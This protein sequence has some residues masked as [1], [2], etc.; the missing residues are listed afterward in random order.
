[1]TQITDH[2]PQFL[3]VWHACIP[4]KSLSY[5]QHDFSNLN[6]GKVLNDFASLNLSFL[7]DSALDVNAKFNRLLSSL[8][9]LV[10]THAPLKKL[11]KSDIKFRNKPWIN[12]KIQKMM[13]IRDNL[14]KKIKK[15]KDQSLID[16]YKQFRNRVT[17]T[18][19][20]S[21]TS[22]FYNY[23][24]KN[25]NNMKQ[26]WSGIKS[27]ISIRKS[28]NVN[29]ISELKDSNGNFTSGPAVIANIFNKFFVNVS[30]DI[31]KNIPPSNKSPLS[32][33]G[34]RVGNSFSMSPSVPSEISDVISVLKSGKSL[35][36]NSIPMKILKLLS[37]LIS[38][39]LSLIINESFQSGVF[40][41][42]MKLAKVIPL[43]KK[44]C[45]L[46]SSNYRPI[47]LLS[48]FSKIVEKVM[49]E[50]LYKFLEKHE[51]LHTLQFGF[52]ASHS[53]NHALV[54]L[55][56]AIKNS[57][58]NRKFGC[59]IFI[60]LQKTF[61]TVNH[62]I[63]LMKLEH[64]GIRGTALDLFK[65]YLSDRKQFVSVNGSNSSH[66]SVTCGVPQGS[67][68]G[69]LLF[70][71][72]I[73]DLP[74]SSSRLD[75]YLFADDT[76]IYYEAESLHHLQNMVNK[77]LKKVKIW[78]NVNK[79][80]LNIDKTNFIIFK[81]PQHSA[82]ET[83][84]I[85]IGNLPI[86]QTCYVKFLGV[87]LDENLSWKYHLTE[88]SKKLART[89]G[90]FFKVRHFLPISVLVCLYNSLFSPFLQ[91]GILVWGLTYETYIKPV[92]LLQKRVLRAISF[93]HHTSPSTPIFS[94]LKILKLHD[95]FQL[96]LLGFVYDCVNKTAP[97]YFH[98]FFALVESVHQYG[99]R[100]AFKNDIF[101]TQKNTLQYGLRSV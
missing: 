93:E 100:Q 68:L 20:E 26:L 1:M 55:T 75:F 91:Y 72:Y 36:P 74:L 21:K 88:L 33:M 50:H 73:N 101:V 35:G 52:R 14:L 95:L 11:A 7:N 6:E 42:K 62:N 64:Y 97:P 46:T 10:K 18:L 92:Y 31:T 5:F 28:N 16:L 60:D 66:L 70:L 45:P 67:V 80:S 53:I 38:S 78:L 54:S 24:Q 3:I 90:M 41:D 94:D 84:S 32:F 29:V 13:R 57:L 56:E 48:V 96:K 71:I 51:I 85:K 98:S 63:L 4:Y 81:S 43:F 86:K 8:E 23:F 17:V 99:T 87:L 9:K 69:P 25:S 44:G 19:R 49:Y 82:P 39:P 89:C 47:S 83:V 22:Y 30:H 15:N 65:S 2:F 59:E 40:P 34:D 12:G 79:L 58:D 61:D 27:A 37:P 77:E 76:N